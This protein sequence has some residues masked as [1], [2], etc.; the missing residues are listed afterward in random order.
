MKKLVLIMVLGLF[1]F[2][3]AACDKTT[4]MAPTT[5]APTTVAPTTAQPTTAAPTTGLITTG[6]TTT[7][8]TTTEYIPTKEIVLS[9]ADWG[10]AELNQILIDAFEAKYPNITVELR[11]DI[12]GS[13]AEFTGNLLNAQAAGV[14][15]DVFAIDNVPTGYYNGM[16]LDITEYWDNDPETDLVYPNIAATAIYN[17]SRYAVPSF[18]FIKGIF[19]NMTLLDTYNITLPDYDW[20]YTEFIDLAREIRQ[21]GK[22]DYVYGI[23]P[24]YGSLDF[25]TT[26]PMQ[27]Y[28][29]VGYNTWD[30]ER[31]NFTSQA[32]ID[33]YNLKLDLMAENVVAAFTEEEMAILG[34]VWPWYVGK[35]GLKIDGSWNLWMIDGMFTEHSIEV[36]FWPYPGGAAGQFPPTILDYQV[37]SSQTENPVEAYMLAKWMT[38]GREGW[39]VR[40]QAMKD[41]GDL[42]IDRFPVSDIPEVWTEIEDFTALVPGLQEN[43][44]LLPYGKPDTDKWLPGYKAFWE[45]VGNEENDYWNRINNGL[46]TPEVF[47]PEWEEQINQMIEEALA[48]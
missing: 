45:W 11:Q 47:A 38:F 32:W 42:M 20:S 33:A 30:G 4:T 44:E 17:G 15:P 5:A 46:V 22:T 31:F 37:V 40:L 16:L 10:D 21:V 2:A 36:G 6:P 9:Y 27:D 7:G 43:V 13:G 12:T 28:A 25:E 14:L 18:Q 41:R 34:D 48:G 23:D 39:A 1:A 19:V 3:L 35:I 26:F 29:E 24:W 8:A